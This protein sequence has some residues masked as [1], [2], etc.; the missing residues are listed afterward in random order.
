MKWSTESISYFLYDRRIGCICEAPKGE[1]MKFV[2]AIDDIF[3]TSDK[4]FILKPNVA[5]ILFPFTFRKHNQAWYTAIRI[6]KEYAEEAI[7]EKE[8]QVEAE[9]FLVSLL[10]NKQLTREEVHSLCVELMGAGEHRPS[11]T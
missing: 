10:K 6:A 11:I 1:V 8:N 7:K 4:I 5:R 3:V 9:G 2:Q